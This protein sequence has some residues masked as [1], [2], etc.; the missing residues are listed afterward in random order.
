VAEGDWLIRWATHAG[1]SSKCWALGID[2]FFRWSFF[3]S[4]LA[5]RIVQRL[6]VRGRSRTPAGRRPGLRGA[7]ET[8]GRHPELLGDPQAC[9]A[10]FL[11]ARRYAEPAWRRYPVLRLLELPASLYRN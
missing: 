5:R 8:G 4:V 9:S 7:S 11:S 2:S 6:R 10:I 3:D 1:S